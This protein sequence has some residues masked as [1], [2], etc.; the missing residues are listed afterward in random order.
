MNRKMI[1]AAA[2]S[3]VAVLATT[4]AALA[5]TGSASDQN[6]RYTRAYV[7]RAY[8]MLSHDQSAYGGHRVAAMND[9][10][11][12]RN[13]LTQAL[14]FDRNP[15]D[16]SIPAGVR[17]EDTDLVNF[18]RG[19]HASTQNLAFVRA[20][21]DHAIDMLQRD[22][23]DYGGFRLKAIASLSDARDQLK[24]AIQYFQA[25]NNSMGGHAGGVASDEN[26]R[27][28]RLY[29]NRAIVMLQHDQ[30]DYAGHRAAALHD[31]EQAQADL[32]AALRYDSNHADQIV[33]TIVMKG[34][35]DLDTFFMRNQFA[36]NENIEF[37]RRYVER[38]IDMLQHD[39]HDYDGFRLK[40]IADLQAAR[41]QLLLA[42]KSR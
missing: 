4:S 25:H 33:P 41:Q 14:H 6:L 30:H 18:V 27:F 2:A 13:D 9:L 26:L 28:T 5:A 10:T 36:S 32:T 21:L 20:Y 16:A 31:I 15:E 23:H 1:G 29:V 22:A 40:A 24:D 8:D 35:E 39:A 38:A 37:V 7:E 17:P 11:M 12:A 42:L 19:Q 3:L 34:D